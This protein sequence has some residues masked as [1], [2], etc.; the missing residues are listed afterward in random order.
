MLTGGW[1]WYLYR[2]YLTAEEGLPGEFTLDMDFVLLRRLRKAP[3]LDEIRFH[4]CRVRLRRHQRDFSSD[5]MDLRPA[6]VPGT[7]AAS[8]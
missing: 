8:P 2:K 1:A 5:A 3:A 4:F 6:H 7:L